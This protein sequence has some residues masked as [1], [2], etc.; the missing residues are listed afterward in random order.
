MQARDSG[1]WDVRMKAA[2]NAMQMQKRTIAIDGCRD[3]VVKLATCLLFSVTGTWFAAYCAAVIQNLAYSAYQRIGLA[4]QIQ[5]L[6]AL[7]KGIRYAST[8]A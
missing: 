6:D 5:N 2:T 7:T 1:M 8:T 3:V 4:R